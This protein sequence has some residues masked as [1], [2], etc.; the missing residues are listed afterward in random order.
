MALLKEILYKA[1]IEEVIGNTN[2]SVTGISINSNEVKAQEMFVALRGANVDG[3]KFIESAVKKGAVAIICEEM[4]ATIQA[5]INY[6][7]VK[8]THIALAE[9]CANF[10]NQPSSFLK[11]VGITGTNGKTTTATLLYKMFMQLNIKCGL[12]S[13][14]ENRINDTVIPATHTTPDP[15]QLNRLLS[16]M[17][18]EGCEYCFMEVSSHAVVQHRVDALQ[19]AGGVFTNIT[20]DHLDY[21]KTFD[22][23]LKAKKKF[24]DML[25]QAAF[26]LVNADDRNGMVMVQ[27]TQ[28]NIKTYGLHS[29]AD[30]RCKIVENNFHGLLLQIDQIEVLCKLIGSFN[31]YNLLAIYAVSVLLG[32]DRQNA[33]TSLST[34]ESVIGRFDYQISPNKITGI[35][36]YAHTPD[37]LQN[38]LS[39]INDIR[40]R[41]E[42]VITVVGC[43][44]NR[45]TAKRPVMAKIAAENSDKVILTSDNPRN[46]DPQ[47]IIEQMRAGVPAHLAAR[48]M[49]ITDRREAIRVA[50]NLAKGGDIILIAGKGHETYQEING[51]KHPFDDKKILNE[52]FKTLNT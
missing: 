34:L 10:Y 52:S 25:P 19:F 46:E 29:M 18:L 51:V 35:V 21:H 3:H 1:G 45:D 26:A 23:Y 9:V 40:T 6:I 30:F 47:S 33:L 42:S 12:I 50:C 8:N 32:I 37:A 43:G 27:N 38:V 2:T 16:R 14:V 36:D 4:P 28:A 22:A 44:G 11:L 49:A 7:R 24:F 17:V 13:T 20:H 31:A 39:T 41:N 5:G 48:V 15:I